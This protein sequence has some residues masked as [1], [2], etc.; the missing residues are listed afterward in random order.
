MYKPLSTVKALNSHSKA[1]AIWVISSDRLLARLVSLA[2]SND[3]RSGTQRAAAREALAAVLAHRPETVE[4]KV[5]AALET[6]ADSGWPS[7]LTSEQG[8]GEERLAAQRLLRALL[9]TSWGAAGVCRDDDALRRILAQ[10]DGPLEALSSAVASG[11]N[12]LYGPVTDEEREA[13]MHA[14]TLVNRAAS[15][16]KAVQ[17]QVATMEL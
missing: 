3:A 16:S 8:P 6:E 5:K 1:G 2:L 7:S 9:G 11:G 14:Q 4:D 10:Q 12:T 13:L 17:P 15:E